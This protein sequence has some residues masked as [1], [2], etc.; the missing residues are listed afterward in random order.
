LPPL[1]GDLSG[2]VS[3]D[4]ILLTLGEEMANIAEAI[5]KEFDSEH[6][7]PSAPERAL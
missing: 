3:L 1:D 2:I 5:R 4:D 7:T 6:P